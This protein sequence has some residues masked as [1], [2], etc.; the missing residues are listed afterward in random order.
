[1]R[2]RPPRRRLCL[3]LSVKITPWATRSML[4]PT[5]AIINAADYRRGSRR[6]HTGMGLDQYRAAH[7]GAGILGAVGRLTV[8][9]SPKIGQGLLNQPL[10]AGVRLAIALPFHGEVPVI[11]LRLRDCKALRHVDGVEVSRVIGF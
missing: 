7:R 3:R 8:A 11:A 2:L 10:G 5:A 6:G 9:A 1:M 4:A